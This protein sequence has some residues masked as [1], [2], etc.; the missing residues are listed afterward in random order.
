MI[1]MNTLMMKRN[2]FELSLTRLSLS[3]ALSIDI[4]TNFFSR[5]LVVILAKRVSFLVF[6]RELI[7]SWTY[8]DDIIERHVYRDVQASAPEVLDSLRR[9]YEQSNVLKKSYLNV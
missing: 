5:W 1:F 3:P 9:Y 7:L 4:V 8:C 2:M 6:I